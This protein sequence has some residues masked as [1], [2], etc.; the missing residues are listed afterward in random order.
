[1]KEIANFLENPIEER[2]A[3]QVIEN[4][5][6]RISFFPDERGFAFIVCKVRDLKLLE[7]IQKLRESLE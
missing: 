1:M 6:V 5:E 4:A 7:K 2:D 3:K